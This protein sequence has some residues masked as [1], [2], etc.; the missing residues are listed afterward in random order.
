M[1]TMTESPGRTHRARASRWLGLVLALLAFATIAS[2][3]V[4]LAADRPPAKTRDPGPSLS[5][6]AGRRGDF[7]EGFVRRGPV[8][9]EGFRGGPARRG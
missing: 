5:Y 6:P 1:T 3:V 4:S 7:H 9:D 2:A 8:V